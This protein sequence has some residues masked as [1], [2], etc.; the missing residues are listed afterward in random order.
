L[1]RIAASKIIDW[2]VAARPIS[3][4]TVSGDLHLV[5]ALDTGVLLAVVDGV[6]HGNEATDVAETAVD[7][8]EKNAGEGIVH[9]VWCCHQALENTRGVVLTVAY[10]DALNNTISWV[11]VGNV[12]GR[13]LRRNG[14]IRGHAVESVLLRGGLVGYRLPPLY[15]SSAPLCVGDLLVFATDG[16]APGFESDLYIAQSPG[17]IADSI[18][19]RHFKGTDDALVL[20]AR[21]L[22]LP[23]GR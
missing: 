13:L 2:C 9:L 20:V 8:L 5:K 7:V 11:G 14:G 16:I 23:N 1:N 17:R 6:G 21:Y 19:N 10:L 18:L 4:Q 22:G 15:V 12:E 3:G